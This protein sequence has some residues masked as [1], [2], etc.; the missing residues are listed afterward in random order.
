MDH[1]E[2][3]V[4]SSPLAQGAAPVSP[5]PRPVGAAG[6]PPGYGGFMAPVTLLSGVALFAILLWYM[7]S[8]V[9]SRRV[10]SRRRTFLRGRPIMSRE[11]WYDHNFSSLGVSREVADTICTNLARIF[12]CDVSQ[13]RSSDRIEVELGAIGSRI[14]GIHDDPEMEQFEYVFLEHFLGADLNSRL[15]SSAHVTTL[16]ELVQW[17]HGHG[18]RGSYNDIVS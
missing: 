7:L 4:L 11:E 14:L 8:S 5:V 16:G 1:R 17:C 18:S 12:G 2:G 9:N 15:R 3:P 13:L 10:R 6:M